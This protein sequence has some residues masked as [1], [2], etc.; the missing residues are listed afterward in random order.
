MQREPRLR[1]LGRAL[2]SVPCEAKRLRIARRRRALV[3][4]SVRCSARALLRRPCGS[5]RER[6]HGLRRSRALQRRVRTQ[7]TAKVAQH[8]R[9]PGRKGAARYARRVPLWRGRRALKK[10]PNAVRVLSK[11]RDAQTPVTERLAGQQRA[12]HEEL[13]LRY[14]R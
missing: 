11:E 7:Y 12:E 13:M 8:G 9:V 14:I 10:A 6:R 1:L 2:E 5:F 3:P 4:Y